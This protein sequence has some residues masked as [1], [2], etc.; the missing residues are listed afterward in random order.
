MPFLTTA[1]CFWRLT[2]SMTSEGKNEYAYYIPQDICNKLIEVKN[3][4]G[5]MVPRPNRDNSFDE[6]YRGIYQSTILLMTKD[7]TF[8]NYIFYCSSSVKDMCKNTAD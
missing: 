7:I 5:C 2:A 1:G 8:K 6:I 4:V 3:F